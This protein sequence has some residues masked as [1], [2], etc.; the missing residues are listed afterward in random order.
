MDTCSTNPGEEPTPA[1]TRD[2]DPSAQS[3]RDR[4]TDAGATKEPPRTAIAE[5]QFQTKKSS[6]ANASLG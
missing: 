6:E 2:L 3:R 4:K 5:A 1:R